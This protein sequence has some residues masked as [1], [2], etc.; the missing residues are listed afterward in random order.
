MNQINYYL[1]YNKINPPQNWRE[2]GI[3][4][5]FQDGEFKSQQVTI[6]DWT[7]VRENIDAIQSWISQGM[8]FEGLPF[9]IDEVQEENG[10]IITIFDGYIDLTDGTLFNEYKLTAKSKERYSIDWLNDTAASFGFEYLATQNLLM[11]SDYVDIPYIISTIPNYKESAIA[12]ISL[13]LSGQMLLASA[14]EITATIIAATSDPLSYGEVL[15]LIAQIINFATS[16]IVIVSLIKKIYNLLVQPVKYHKGIKLRTL[17]EKGCAHLNLT[18]DSSIIP[19]DWVILPKKYV[20]PANPDNSDGLGILGAFQPNEFPQFGYPKENFSDFIIKM[21]DLFNGKVLMNPN[22]GHLRFERRD[23]STVAPQYM[24]PP[25]EN[26]SYQ[27][28]T[29][30]IYSNLDITFLTDTVESNTITQYKGTGYQIIQ[31]PAFIL[32][33]E[34]VLMKGLRE[35]NIS[36]ALGKRKTE[37]TTVEKIFDTLLEA[38]DTALMPVIF[39]INTSIALVNDLIDIIND[40]IAFLEAV[41]DLP[42]IGDIFSFDFPSIPTIEPIP[43]SSFGLIFDNRIGM[44]LL[45]ND[46]FMQDKLLRII[47]DGRLHETQPS[48]RLLYNNYY[49]IEMV[50]NQWKMQSF[51][52]VPFVTA[53]YL[54]VKDNPNAYDENGNI[55][56]IE[57]VIYSPWTKIAS[58]KTRRQNNYTNNLILKEV[59]PSGE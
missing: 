4:C 41:N 32:R 58:I 46:Y 33:P 45:E 56:K 55:I 24:L 15:R 47:S 50:N 42:L 39:S 28:N 36:Y 27:L 13:T 16:I 9:R 48:A 19:E 35:V 14:S 40:F 38:L 53:D 1:N 25:I 10:N 18:F 6:T 20:I 34:F 3:E 37:L 7:F 57:S 26:T 21:K 12:I 29:S 43:Y 22:T 59:E 2:L 11:N 17:F 8:I 30:E 31:R 23:Y 5:N 49:N 51:D 54:M 52:K 44:L